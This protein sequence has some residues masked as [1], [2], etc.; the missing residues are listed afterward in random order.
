MLYK[1]NAFGNLFKKYSPIAASLKQVRH[2]MMVDRE[3]V[4]FNEEGLPDYL[5]KNGRIR[6]PATFLG[7]RKD[8]KAAQVKREIPQAVVS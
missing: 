8:R 1:F 2:K 6:K 3:V 5:D 7:F 4:E